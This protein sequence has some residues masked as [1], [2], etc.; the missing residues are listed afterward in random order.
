MSAKHPG[1]YEWNAGRV[2]A[3]RQHMGLTQQKFAEE[4]GTEQQRVSEWETGM[5]HPSRITTTLLSLV[6]ER[7]GFV[8]AE[9]A[10]ETV[11]RGETLEDFRQRPVAD[12]ELNPRAVAALSRA[13]L[14]EVG[15]VLDLLAQGGGALLAVPGFGRRSLEELE[16]RLAERGLKY[17]ERSTLGRE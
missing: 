7:S 14:T 3:L 1:R 5:H 12:L 11:T 17:K 2:R 4:L 6:A 16:A 10:E 9:P 8:Y 13:G 15:Q